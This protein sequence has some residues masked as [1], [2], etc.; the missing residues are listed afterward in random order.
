MEALAV[1]DQAMRRE[2]REGYEQD[3]AELIPTL[4]SLDLSSGETTVTVE[5]VRPFLVA[6]S[7]LDAEATAEAQASA[8]GNVGAVLRNFEAN[9]IIVREGERVDAL[10][11]EVMDQLDLRKSQV[12]WTDYVGGGILA[13]LATTLLFLYLARFEPN[14]V[15]QGHQ[16]ILLVVLA[17]AFLLIAGIMVP[18]GSVLRYLSPMPALAMLAAATLAPIPESGSLCSRA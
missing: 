2:I 5:L 10:D 3:V 1:L 16:L 12:D 11:I 7:F 13:V 14:T 9:E 6:N 17:S 15:W 8:R 18:S 4:V